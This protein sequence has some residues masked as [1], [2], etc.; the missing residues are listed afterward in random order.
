VPFFYIFRQQRCLISCSIFNL[1]FLFLF[2]N[3]YHISI[4]SRQF[5][6][7]NKL[8]GREVKLKGFSRRKFIQGIGGFGE[9][10]V[11]YVS[12]NQTRAETRR[13]REK[14]KMEIGIICLILLVPV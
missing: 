6:K 12:L 2:H 8:Y 11:D 5:D 4:E 14:Q 10:N 1:T 3:F 13:R 9:I 7:E